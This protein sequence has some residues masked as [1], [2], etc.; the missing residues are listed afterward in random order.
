[1]MAIT[2]SNGNFVIS[3]TSVSGTPREGRLGG[4][5]GVAVAVGVPAALLAAAAVL[6]VVPA[7]GTT[8]VPDAAVAE[9]AA[10][11][12]TAVAVTDGAVGTIVSSTPGRSTVI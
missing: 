9:G 4:A 5:V 6:D 10:V 3:N 2:T 11:V 1:M 7:V 8:A 12:A